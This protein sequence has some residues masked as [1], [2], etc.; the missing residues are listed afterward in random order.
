VNTGNQTRIWL[1]STVLLYFVSCLMGQDNP[2]TT[3]L[4]K[5]KV[6]TLF[7]KVA[8]TDSS[9]RHIT[10]LQKTDFRVYEDNI[11]QPISH[12]SHESEPI[13]MGFVI[14]VSYSMKRNLGWYRAEDWFS[15]IVERDKLHPQDEYFL[16]TFNQA[17]RLPQPFSNKIEELEKE[18]ALQQPGGDTA[19][20]DA[21]Y[22]GIHQFR[23]AKHEKKAMILITDGDD[24]N[25]R[26]RRSE[27]REYAMES[28][29]QIYIFPTD[30][31]G[32]SF[33]ETLAGMTG[34]RLFKTGHI[35][36]YIEFIHR[37]LRNQYLLGY[38]PTNKT[39]DGKWRQIKVKL[40]TPPDFPKLSIHTKSGYYAP[41]N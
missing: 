21:I 7:L 24:N 18:V 33:L 8:V 2:S 12:F 11:L 35:M 14:D 13:S 4:F 25:S 39:R 20:L 27:V 15:Q 34:G 26:Y 10:G 17:V 16:I 30:T 29:A 41:E 37:E 38:I 36:G 22:L 9:N 6:D 5:V 32:R 31:F 3:P 23:E 28:E 1:I 19:L 40:D